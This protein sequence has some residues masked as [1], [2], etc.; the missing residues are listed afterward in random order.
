MY[1]D[2]IP[3]NMV[4]TYCSAQHERKIVDRH[5][6]FMLHF[7]MATSILPSTGVG[8]TVLKA[9]ER[10]QV[11]EVSDYTFVDSDA[12]I[13]SMLDSLVELP[14][15]PPSLYIDLEGVR[16][17]RYGSISVLQIFV[18]PQDHTYLVDVHHLRGRAFT[19]TG[20]S[21][22]NTL[23]SILESADI[24]KVIFD[25][26][27]DSDAL[28]HHFQV[29]LAG[30]EDLQL[31]EI[32]TRQ[33][34]KRFLNGLSR[35]IERDCPMTFQDEKEW[36]SVKENGRKMFAPECG[37]SYEVFNERP[38]AEPMVRYCIQDVQLL[39]KLWRIYDR[40]L[41]SG[42]R[43]KVKAATVERIRYSQGPVYIGEGKHKA[44]PPPGW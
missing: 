16:L 28:F 13:A 1:R 22:Q 38:M 42:W 23:K 14:V 30:V 35:C 26:R 9:L 40:K 8:E 3:R 24:P 25:V 15:S 17:S 19:V 4:V 18:L 41:T 32:A 43:V 27:I 12:T 34:P 37:G 20:K 7:V 36:R 31:M 11:E 29:K 39:G 5:S 33:G 21:K 10:L 6:P 2:Y 44:L